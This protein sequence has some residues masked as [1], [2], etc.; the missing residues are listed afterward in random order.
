MDIVKADGRR[1]AFRKSKIIGS[2]V[3]AGGSKEFARDIAGKVSGK[4]HGGETTK[5]VLDLTLRNL[6]QDRA[7]AARYNLKQAIMG[8]GPAGFA[9]EEY[10]SQVLQA[11][12]YETVTGAHIRGKNILQ[13]IDVVARKMN[14]TS[15]I[16]AKYHN[17]RGSRTNTKVAMYTHARF[18]DVSSNAKNSFA[19]AWL[20]T[21]TSVTH[22]ARDYSRGVRLRIVSWDYASK[23]ASLRE[24]IEAEKLYPITIFTCVSK[25]VREKLFRA[26]VVLAKDLV[27]KDVDEIHQKTGVSKRDIENV[28]NEITG[29][30]AV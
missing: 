20:V 19:D 11:R 15:M 13:E 5:R 23:G 26:K 14:R 17:Q 4:I 2:I 24:M 22:S 16:E 21:N 30:C 12:G 8:L 6:K 9:F 18:L 27:D 28:L 3:R 7:V 1:V 29:I 25:K 10:I